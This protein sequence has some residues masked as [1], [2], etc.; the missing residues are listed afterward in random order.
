MTCW[1]SWQRRMGT[2]QH[3]F[4]AN[5]LPSCARGKE[6]VQFSCMD[7]W[8]CS[9]AHGFG[10]CHVPPLVIKRGYAGLRHVWSSCA[11]GAERQ[12]AG[13]DLHHGFHWTFSQSTASNKLQGPEIVQRRTGQGQRLLVHDSRLPREHRAGNSRPRRLGV[14]VWILKGHARLQQWVNERAL[15]GKA[16]CGAKLQIGACRRGCFGVDAVLEWTGFLQEIRAALASICQIEPCW[17]RVLLKRAYLV[18]HVF[19]ILLCAWGFATAPEAQK[20]LPLSSPV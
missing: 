2:L 17:A 10:S 12:K 18:S 8:L 19:G 4:D 1:A 5:T 3:G 11:D 9:L 14:C 15:D 6:Q 7:C 16:A 20:S 13:E